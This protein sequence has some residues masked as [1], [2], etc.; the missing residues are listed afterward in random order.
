MINGLTAT[1]FG[2]SGFLGRV[3]VQVLAQRGYIVRVPTRD[4]E[5]AGALKVLGAP[6]QIVPVA[7]SVRNDAA[8]AKAM[9]GA[10]LIVNL[11]GILSEK[12]RDTFQFAHVETAARL[13]RIARAEGVA[14]FIHLSA[15]GADITSRA[16]YAR[17]KAIGE[18][19]VHAFFPE[20]VIF[21]PGVLFGPRDRFLNR[22]AHAARLSPLL[23]LI[24]GGE[25][26][27]QPVYVGDVAAAILSVL[28][29][30][31]AK[32]KIFLLGGPQ[33]YA[34]KALL[35]RIC[36]A[37]GLK[38][39]FLPLPWPLAKGAAFFLEK[40]PDP[41]FT[42]DQVELLKTDNILAASLCGAAGIRYRTF[43]DL[44]IAPRSLE[45]LFPVF[46]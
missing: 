41:P 28:D 6:G 17:T 23:P 44:S 8:V 37:Q 35:A 9:Q 46:L 11:I 43:A 20:A 1:I 25:T 2:G 14:H 29:K 7:L 40:L 5:K 15:L 34:V 36:V 22:F 30:P 10:D 38:R 12:G 26:R 3:V 21:R 27:L 42:R 31:E 13:A 33:T 24:G 18:E 4:P 16:R 19:A 32:G 45:D 39:L